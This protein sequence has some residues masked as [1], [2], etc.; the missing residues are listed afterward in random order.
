MVSWDGAARRVVRELLAWQPGNEEPKACPADRF[1]A[2][3]PTRCGDN[4]TCLPNLCRFEVIDSWDSRGKPLTRPQ[5]AQMLSG[6]GPDT[7]GV[8]TN[9]GA[10]SMPEGYTVYERLKAARGAELKTVHIAGLKYVSRGVTAKAQRNGSIDVFARRGGPDKRTGSNTTRR[11]LPILDS[12]LGGPFFAFIHYKEADVTAHLQSV[13]SP[14]YREALIAIDRE[15]GVLL[16]ELDAKGAMP[17]T[18]VLVTT[19]HGFTGRFH[20]SRETS[21]T[22]TWIAALNLE[23]RSDGYAKLL[24]VTPTIYDFFGV[25]V[26]SLDPPLE[27]RSLLHPL[28]GPSAST[29]TSSLPTTSTTT[30]STTVP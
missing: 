23:L 16:A 22:A 30:T 29:T 27:G 4:W 3:L 9:N 6:Y 19:D 28:G 26:D 12:V 13:D 18:S 8:E 21:N 11:A 7:T 10:A 2:T 17:T 14:A 25:D 1:T 15:L 5:H 24:D 20:V